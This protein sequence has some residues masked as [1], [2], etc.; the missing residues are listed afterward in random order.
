M[1]WLKDFVTPKIKAFMENSSSIEENLWTKCPACDRMIYTKELETNLM[2]CGYCSHHF[3]ISSKARFESLFDGKSFEEID[4]ISIKD[5]PLKYKDLKK[6]SDRLKDSRQKTGKQEAI[7]IATG[8]IKGKNAVVFIMDFSFMGGS[9][10]LSVGKSI[11]KAAQIAE[12]NNA[13]LIGFTASGGARMQEGM[14]SLMQMPATIAA[15]TNLKEQGLP[16]INVFTNPTTGGVMASFAVL[17]D[18]H[19]AEPKALIGFAGARVIE[20][21]IKQK[22]PS[23]FQRSEFLKDHGLIDMIINRH[24]LAEKLGELLNYMMDNEHAV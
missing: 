6:Y 3:P 13:A 2:V 4:I 22:L 23:G 12:Q 24:N 1:N 15:I 5:D 20:K 21:T 7:S 16:Y 11:I 14:L 18:I 10:G 19:I 9:M 17:G 8:K